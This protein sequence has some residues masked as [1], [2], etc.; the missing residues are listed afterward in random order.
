[1][2]FV[3]NIGAVFDRPVDKPPRVFELAVPQAP[4]AACP[5]EDVIPDP[6]SGFD[7]RVFTI[8]H[9]R[10]ELQTFIFYREDGISIDK[11]LGALFGG[12]RR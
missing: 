10:G 5:Y 8:E 4:T 11:A 6:E 2:R 7:R 1:M 9:I 3:T 12:G